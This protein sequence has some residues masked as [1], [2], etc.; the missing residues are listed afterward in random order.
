MSYST[1]HANVSVPC[2]GSSET[3]WV[4]LVVS[5]IL[6]CLMHATTLYWAATA[7]SILVSFSGRPVSSTPLLIRNPLPLAI[8]LLLPPNNL[9][10]NDL[11]IWWPNIAVEIGTPSRRRNFPLFAEFFHVANG[12]F[13]VTEILLEAPSRFVRN[14]LL[15]A[16]GNVFPQVSSRVKHFF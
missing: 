14:F 15:E 7:F 10:V 6:N 8:F 12:Y 3:A 4:L 13:S 11:W 1:I 16:R 2:T 5:G 9:G